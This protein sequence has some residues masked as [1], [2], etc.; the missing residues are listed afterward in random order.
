MKNTTKPLRKSH[1]KSKKRSL[2]T[3]KTTSSL[4]KNKT[5]PKK[6]VLKPEVADPAHS[7]GHRKLNIIENFPEN[8]GPKVLLQESAVN[9]LSNS[10]KMRRNNSK[11]RRI[12]TGATIGKTG[13]IIIK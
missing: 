4:K 13:R 10:D 1:I 5:I 2:S 12:I 6:V 3:K 8:S 9:T 7:Y 11:N